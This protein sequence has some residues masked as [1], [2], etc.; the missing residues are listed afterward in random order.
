LKRSNGRVAALL[1]LLL[2]GCGAR[3]GTHLDPEA[4]AQVAAEV[5][6]YAQGDL[7]RVKYTTYGPVKVTSCKWMIWDPAPTE[8]D[9]MSQLLNRARTMNANGVTN[10]SCNNPGLN[11][12]VRDCWSE[13]TCSG[14]AIKVTGSSN[15]R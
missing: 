2:A 14:E 3:E 1:F 4:S 7:R 15:Q 13:V 10:V 8:A 11:S 6:V 9:V 5:K 12:L